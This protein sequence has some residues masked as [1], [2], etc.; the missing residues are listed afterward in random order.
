[1]DKCPFCRRYTL[2]SVRQPFIPYD[3]KD[4]IPYVVVLNVPWTK[5]VWC[6]NLSLDAKTNHVITK[7]LQPIMGREP[8]IQ[9]KDGIKILSI[10]LLNFDTY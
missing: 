4:G 2:E 10:P 7:M 9:E 1:M 3:N 5:C 8:H 6:Q